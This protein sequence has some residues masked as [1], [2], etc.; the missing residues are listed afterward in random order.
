MI[1]CYSDV[2]VSIFTETL[3]MAVYHTDTALV[4]LRNDSIIVYN[5]LDYSI[6]NSGQDNFNRYQGKELLKEQLELSKELKQPYSGTV[7]KCVKKNARKAIDLMLQCTESHKVY[8]EILGYDTDFQIGMITL[9]LSDNSRFISGKEC[10]KTCLRPF[11]D[12]LTKTK[13][14]NFY[15]WKAERQSSH[16]HSGNLKKSNGQLH[17]HVLID[18]YVNWTEVKKKWNSLQAAAG[19]LADFEAKYN[20]TN[21]NSIDIHKMYSVN[22][23]GAYLLKYITKESK[24]E[25][26]ETDEDFQNRT[27]VG[28]KVWDCSLNLKGRKFYNTPYTNDI[29]KNLS[30][31]VKSNHVVK[32]EQDFCTMYFFKD[33]KPTI[34]LPQIKRHDYIVHLSSIINNEA[35]PKKIFVTAYDRLIKDLTRKHHFKRNNPPTPPD[36][37]KTRLKR[38]FNRQSE[39]ISLSQNTI[40]YGKE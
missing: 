10:H 11:L 7:T 20:H 23:L 8:N 37:K 13:K 28:G 22:D 38:K 24:R 33:V 19:Y 5:K 21:P 6:V 14:C 1:F 29:E 32:M 31:L 12:W 34:V 27:S 26:N 39:L 30:Y 35:L 25:E 2:N 9:T 36:N 3:H 18:I 16:D 15:L 40:D 4:Q 17:Y